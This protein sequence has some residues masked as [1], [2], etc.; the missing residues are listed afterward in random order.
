MEL[1]NLHLSSLIPHPLFISWNPDL[2]IG[3][4]RWYSLCWLIGLALAYFIVRK[5]YKDQKLGDDK[6]EPLFFYCFIGILLGARLGH[7]IFYQPQDFLTSWQ[8]IVEMILPIQL[9][10]YLI[11]PHLE[12]TLEFLKASLY[13][14]YHP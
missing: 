11:H 9:G 5:L 2:N 8:G 4:I 12:E 13:N 7:C 10:H 6:F 3:P 14:L 1:L